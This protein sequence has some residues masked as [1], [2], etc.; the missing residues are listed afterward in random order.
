MTACLRPIRA[1]LRA[2]R[3]GSS[4]SFQVGLPVL[5]LQN[6]HRRVHVSPRI[7]NVAVPRCQHS[8]MFGQAASRQTVCRLSDSI[9]SLS[10]RYLCPPGAGTLNHGGFRD[11]WGRT[12]SPPTPS[13][14]RTS[15]IPPGLARERVD[16][17]LRLLRSFR[18]PTRHTFSCTLRAM[19][20]AGREIGTYGRLDAQVAELAARQHLVFTLGHLVAEGLSVSAVHKRT[21]TGRLHRVH[22]GVYSLVP[23]D[24]LTWRGRYL[25]AVLACGDGAAVSH[26]EAAAL[27]NLRPSNRSA[28]DVTTRPGIPQ[29]CITRQITTS[30]LNQ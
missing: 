15:A 26:R 13:T 25:A 8:P 29:T 19:P 17:G 12:S 24:Q 9:R 10:S 27:H 7:M 14:V 22:R 3:S 23:A 4:G 16:T 5:T 1:T 18:A 11:L 20:R 21:A 2:T 6:P 30:T 28:I